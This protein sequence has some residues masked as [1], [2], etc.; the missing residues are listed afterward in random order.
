MTSQAQSRSKTKLA[1]IV[2]FAALAALLAYSVLKPTN[3]AIA[4]PFW[5]AANNI[6]QAHIDHSKWQAL[7]DKHLDAKHASGINRFAYSDV[8]EASKRELNSYIQELASVDPRAFSKNEQEA[9]WI[10]LY[11][12]LTVRLIVDNAPV[13]S[14]TNLGDN[15]TSFG[16]W[17]DYAVTVAGQDL[18]LNDIEHSILR[19][20]WQDP[21][22]HYAVNCASIG[23]PNLM[24]TAFTAA[25]LEQQLEQAAHAYVNHERGVSFVDDELWVSSIYHWYKVDFGDSD[26]TLIE[27]LA[28][29]AKPELKQKLQAH[30][31]GIEHDY[32][33]NLNGH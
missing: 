10:N 31:G 18:S 6:S 30:Q 12:A 21:R 8:N 22:I 15:L 24:P 29:Y 1:L 7:L 20:I 25:N 17:D 27:H 9:Y 13:E 5:D 14:I 16:P 33:W 28:Q 4:K 23:C 19:P 32:D 11:N 3:A 26:E 2:A